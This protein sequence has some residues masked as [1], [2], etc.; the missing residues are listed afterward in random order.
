M[1]SPR[2]PVPCPLLLGEVGSA[3]PL[4][5]QLL[6]TQ[7]KQKVIEEVRA[8]I[9]AHQLTVLLQQAFYFII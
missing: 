5:C 3:C 1:L 2:S 8:A 7:M 6:R 4:L 9:A